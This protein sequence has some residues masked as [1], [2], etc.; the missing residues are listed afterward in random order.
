[1]DCV[2][3]DGEDG[4]LWEVVVAER[5]TGPRRNDAW[6]SEGRGRVNAEGFGYHIV[7]AT[8]RVSNPIKEQRA[9]ESYVELT[10]AN[11]SPCHIPAHPRLR[12]LPR[13]VPSVASP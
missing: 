10:R 9:S 8:G 6:K 12:E 13:Q 7:E 4:A 5:D 1:M 2:G 3:G 11:P